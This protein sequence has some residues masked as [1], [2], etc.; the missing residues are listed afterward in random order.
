MTGLS[1]LSSEVDPPKKLVSRN[2][3]GNH[4]KGNPQPSNV[5]NGK[6]SSNTIMAPVSV[7]NDSYTSPL[8]REKLF[9]EFQPLVRRLL[10]RY[11]TNE[12]VRQEMVGEIYYR[13]CRLIDAYDP[14][15]GIPLRPYV[16]T[17]LSASVHTYARQCWT[18][19]TRIAPLEAADGSTAKILSS[20]PTADW[21]R[22][23]QL[24]QLQAALP[25]AFGQ[26]SD[27]QRQIVVWRYYEGL[28]YDE[29]AERLSIRPASV[30]SLLSH[31][32]KNLRVWMIQHEL[33]LDQ[34][35]PTD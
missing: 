1:A 29:I 12:E 32:L 20:D 14:K 26:I 2:S 34:D 6:L 5:S 21:D 10:R 7:L 27:R 24:Q 35:D 15:R 4:G 16:V 9:A 17:A 31:G 8:S 25:G 30:R 13:F 28:S 11:G 33:R 19:S 22:K 18:H 3:L 23:L